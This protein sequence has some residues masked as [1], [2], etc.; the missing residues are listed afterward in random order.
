LSAQA[1]RHADR[2]AMTAIDARF[3]LPDTNSTTTTCGTTS[4]SN[5]KSSS[6]RDDNADLMLQKKQA[7]Q[8]LCEYVPDEW[9]QRLYTEYK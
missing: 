1:K 9:K 8:I 6:I 4:L 2:Q 5:T 7:V 3:I